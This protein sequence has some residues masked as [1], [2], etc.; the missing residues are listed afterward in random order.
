MFLPRQ[1]LRAIWE[2]GSD[3]ILDEHVENTR[4]TEHRRMV[5]QYKDGRTY[6]CGYGRGLTEEQ[7]QSP[8]DDNEDDQVNCKEV[9]KR[10]KEITVYE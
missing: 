9:Q 7:F 5:F 8:F 6:A 1:E 3:V 2:D 10:T 4:W